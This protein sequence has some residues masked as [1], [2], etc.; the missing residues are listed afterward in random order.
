MAV[1]VQR[2]C[3]V[4]T[5][6]ELLGCFLNLHDRTRACR[7]YVHDAVSG[8]EVGGSGLETVLGLPTPAA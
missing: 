6:T 1:A 4:A 5:R 7:E 2:C 3:E 8:L